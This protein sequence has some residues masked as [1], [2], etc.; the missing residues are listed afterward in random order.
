MLSP[1]SS[2]RVQ[3]T[4]PR[5]G[6]AAV[7]FAFVGPILI[8]IVVASV[9]LGRSVM[10]LDLLSHAARTGCRAGVLPSN[11]NGDVA[12]AVNNSLAAAGI[13]GAGTPAIDVLPQGTT[14][15]TSPGDAGNANTGDAVRVT[16]SVPYARVSWLGFNWFMSSGAK[17]SSSVVMCKE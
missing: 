1:T 2:P 6:A 4:R 11:G 15:W 3:A 16:V 13:S 7:E 9:E 12:T 8:M 14:T 17:L 5:T 10:V